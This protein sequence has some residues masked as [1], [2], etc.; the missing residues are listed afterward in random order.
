MNN[1]QYQELI[2]ELVKSI[3]ESEALKVVLY[4]VQKIVGRGY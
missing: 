4:V 1:E 2:I 3:G